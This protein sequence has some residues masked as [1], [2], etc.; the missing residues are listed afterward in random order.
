M[1]RL[2]ANGILL[3]TFANKKMSLDCYLTL[4][5]SNNHTMHLILYLPHVSFSLISMNCPDLAFSTSLR[6][7]GLAAGDNA[8]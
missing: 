5:R 6:G 4:I 1:S 2:A 8:I 3:D 7:K